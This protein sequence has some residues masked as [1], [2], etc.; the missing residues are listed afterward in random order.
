MTQQQTHTHPHIH[1][2][3][4][5][6]LDSSCYPLCDQGRYVMCVCVCAG[7]IYWRSVLD[8]AALVSSDVCESVMID[9]NGS[10][11]YLPILHKA[12]PS[13]GSKVKVYSMFDLCVCVH[14]R[15][16]VM[17]QSVYVCVCLCVW[18]RTGAARQ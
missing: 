10:I 7:G 3:T 9:M 5:S 17:H 18:Q 14:M 13:L 11:G 8:L 6:I 15:A 1:N 2:A 12:C 4:L 16:S